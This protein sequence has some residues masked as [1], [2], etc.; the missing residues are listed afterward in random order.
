MQNKIKKLENYLEKR[1]LQT[2]LLS[3]QPMENLG[4]VVTIPC[5][6][7]PNLLPT[8]QSIR[9]CLLPNC[10]T[11]VI[12]L[13]ND[14]P[15]DKDKIKQHNQETLIAAS[16]FA[17]L[18]NKERLRFYPLYYSAISRK[19]SGVGTARKIAMDEALRRFILVNNPHGIITGLDADTLV[20]VNYLQAI[21][22]HFESNETCQA[23][24]IHYE[25]PTTG[26]S[27][28]PEN[29]QA[30]ITYE[31]H[32]RY[33]V[34]ALRAAGLPTAFQTVGSA[35]AVQ[36]SAYAAQ[37]GMPR[38]QAGE[39]FY[40]IHKFTGLGGFQE[41]TR[42]TV[43]P[44]PRTSTRVPFGTGKAIGDILAGQPF[45]TH[46]PASFYALEKFL[47]QVETLYRQDYSAIESEMPECMRAFLE[48]EK[49]E[50]KLQEIKGN[51]T[52]EATFR[53][54]FFVWFDAFKA[55]KYVHFVRDHFY[56][57]QVVAIA[58]REWL[59]QQQTN[60][61]TWSEL[62]LLSHFRK[63]DKYP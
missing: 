4:L 62:D 58:V 51:T 29:Y 11:E 25:H 60:A 17:R 2:A 9:A 59:T 63:L 42:T 7:E 23:A 30:I 35:M 6:H 28:P 8:L 56:P 1:A 55:M 34:H 5:R 10:A 54:R 49:F 57:D 46:A 19:K 40:F 45:L 39:D 52:S 33:Y 14:N 20:E 27:Y 21:H 47:S 13:I 44:S 32:L 36:A 53:K 61:T 37:G 18:H 50:D 24:S 41:I 3:N 48:T 15:Q 26:T 16:E 12:I 43:I 31:L 38:R 22:Q